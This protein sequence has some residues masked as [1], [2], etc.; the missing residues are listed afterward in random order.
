MKKIINKPEE[1]TDDMLRGIYMAH[2][3]EVR[4]VNDDLRCYCTC[5][6]ILG[7]VAI[8]TGGGTGHLPLFLGYVGKGLLDGCGVGGV[9]QSPS[10]EQ[11]YQISKAVDNGAGILYLYGNYTGDIMTFDMAAEMCEMDNIHVRSIVGADDVCSGRPEVRRGVAGIFYMYKAAGAKAAEMGSLDEVY[12]AA[13]KAKENTRTVGFALT[14]CI[15]PEVGKPNFMLGENEMAMGM[16][17]H[18]EPGV[19]NG[20]LKTS[21]EL[22]AESIDTILKDMPLSNGEEVS[23]LINGLGA[24]S[25]EEQY[26]LCG[27]VMRILEQKGIG[28]YRT[29]VGEYA[30]SMEMAGASISICRVDEEMKRYLDYP[31]NTPFVKNF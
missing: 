1:Y 31:V 30:T 16:G 26:I 17:I 10:P 9:F 5:E 3:G 8:V 19:W 29:Y 13:E 4:Y 23:V 25:L 28:V 27:D 24:T 11:I 22:A 15:I 14:P 12:T 2:K 20:P 21:A 18:G 7:K 6:K